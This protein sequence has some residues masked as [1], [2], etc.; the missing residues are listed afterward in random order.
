MVLNDDGLCQHGVL[1]LAADLRL[2]LGVRV[3]VLE[4]VG[5]HV[6]VDGGAGT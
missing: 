6:V 4:D 3:G 5:S 2:Q 1:H